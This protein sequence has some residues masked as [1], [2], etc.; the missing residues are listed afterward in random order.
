MKAPLQNEILKIDQSDMLAKILEFPD[1]LMQGLRIAGDVELSDF[2]RQP[3]QLVIGGMGGSAIAGDMVKSFFS[4][5]IP[6]PVFVN[7]GYRLPGFV[8]SN[9]LFIASSYSGNTE[10][11]LSATQEA[12]DRGCMIL[13]ITSGGRLR[14]LAKA[15]GYP[16]F[17]LP[18]GYPPRSALGYSLSVLISILKKFNFIDISQD[19]LEEVVTFLRKTAQ[20]WQTAAETTCLPLVLA[21]KLQGRIP[22]IYSSVERLESVGSRWK[23]QLNENSKAHAFYFPF[24]EMNH[25]EIMGWYNHP[26][27][28]KHSRLFIMVLLRDA[29][30][31]SRIALR[32]DIT[33]S[34]LE[35]S[36]Y[37]VLE[38]HSEGMSGLA[39]FLYLVFLGDM[40]SFYLAVLYRVDPTEI[41]NIDRLKIELSRHQ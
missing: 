11:T 12:V 2:A 7:R 20:S 9:T 24:P 13:C 37:E 36:E 17:I 3:A 14:E 19:T 6:I 16:L 8:D 5:S 31:A 38:I 26:V 22:L 27:F 15:N 40:I 29:D 18:P 28:E 23:A 10:E 34:L 21:R 1:Q 41:E 32:M 39:R 25:N 4:D 35:N 30:D 33:K